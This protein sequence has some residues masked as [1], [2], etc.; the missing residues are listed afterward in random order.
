MAG[1]S[2]PSKDLST[3]TYGMGQIVQSYRGH[4]LVEHGGSVPGHMTQVTRFPDDKV[5]IFISAVDSEHGTQYHAVAKL[6]IADHV[7]GLEPKESPLR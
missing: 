6:I 4:A 3:L 1:W 5:G 2:Q 7:F